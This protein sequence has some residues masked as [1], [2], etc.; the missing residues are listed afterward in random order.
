MKRKFRFP[1][2]LKSLLV[3]VTS[4]ALVSVV[5]I[6]FS[7][8][9][10]KNITRNHYEE[11]SIEVAD[12]LALYIDTDDYKELKA[13]VKERF[14]SI[15]EEEK[16]SNESWGEPEWESYLSHF[17]D[18]VELDCYKNLL[19]QIEEF[20][21]KN[22]VENLCIVYADIEGQRIVYVCDGDVEEE[23]CMPGSFD[24]F[25]EQDTSITEHIETGFEPEV[26]NMEEYGY[27]VSVGRPIYDE[28]KQVIGFTLVE[29]SMDSIV[30]QE[31]YNTMILAII[32][33]ILGVIAVF[34]GYLLIITLFVT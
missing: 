33:S 3:L 14:D 11:H 10:L 19:G 16:V 13:V 25:T 2:W 4:V 17:E 30:A 23:R 5:A 8:N 1:I 7:S 28:Y 26:T 31:S 20:H 18:I 21:S 34:I 29:L 15:P 24:W 27:L 9:T 32:L 22:D 12:T 6:V